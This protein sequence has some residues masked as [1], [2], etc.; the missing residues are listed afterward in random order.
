MHGYILLTP[1]LLIVYVA[2]C[3]CHFFSNTSFIVSTKCLVAQGQYSATLQRHRVGSSIRI[4]PSWVH[5]YSEPR[6]GY[7]AR[8]LTV[9]GICSSSAR[10]SQCH[11]LACRK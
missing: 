9:F 8:G 3:G 7:D 6:I 11:H 1:W 10:F 4:L 5:I 2:F